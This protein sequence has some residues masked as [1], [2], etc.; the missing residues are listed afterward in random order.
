MSRTDTLPTS[1]VPRIVPMLN[2]L[3]RRLIGVGVPFGPNVLLTVRGR[4]SGLPRTFP[5]ALMQAGGR[6]LVQSPY[7]EPNWVHNLRADPH[8]I[9]V[10]GDR[11]D[12]VEAV[13]LPPEIAA[14]LIRDAVAPYMRR[15]LTA[16][17]ARLFIP[18]SRDASIDEYVELAR[19]HPTFE[20]RIR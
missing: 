8:A 10:R 15:R 17:L 11:R 19:R 9:L 14:P 16:A 13:E 2:P 1:H 12:E 4:R 7:G 5:V 18:V 20:L 6:L 3:V